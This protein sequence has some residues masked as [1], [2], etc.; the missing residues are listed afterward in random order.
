[1]EINS[2]GLELIKQFEGCI[3]HSYKDCVGVLT[4]GYGHTQGVKEGQVITQAQAEDM[5]RNDLKV[6]EREV[7]QA[8]SNLNLNENQF[9][10]L[11]SFHYNT[12]CIN[13]LV[14]NRNKEQIANAILLYNKAGGKVLE[15]LVRRRKAE[16]Q[17][18]LTPVISNKS[19]Y[20][21]HLR[22]LQIAYNKDYK[23][24]ILTDGIY[25]P[26]TDKALHNIILKQG[27][28]NDLVAWVQIRISNKI[29]VDGI[30]GN[31]TRN[32]VADYQRK[33]GLAVDGIVGYN[34]IKTILKQY[35]AI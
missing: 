20:S 19:S 13:T 30:F 22:D 5:L 10:A 9:S 34:T 12:G 7:T 11:V 35:K 32:A 4:I 33:H 6:Y 8:T 29:D 31:D 2:K 26:Q 28:R 25:G 1:M 14:A 21:Y 16:Q 24:N 23:A 15:G 17:L 3:L 18:F 27:T